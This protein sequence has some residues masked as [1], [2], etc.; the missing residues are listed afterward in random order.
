M[1]KNLIIFGILFIIVT[2]SVFGIFYAIKKSKNNNTIDKTIDIN[3]DIIDTTTDI[4]DSVGQEILPTGDFVVTD[5]IGLVI[6]SIN[7]RKLTWS[8]S[9][10]GYI[11]PKFAYDIYTK[12]MQVTIDDMKMDK[13]FQG[14]NNKG[15]TILNL[16]GDKDYTFMF[17][18]SLKIIG[19][20]N[21]LDV[22]YL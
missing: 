21:V 10:F 18:G 8:G 1:K 12:K 13:N 2:L 7:G 6:G 9:P 16:D 14:Y 5:E 19:N 11:K 4:V 22:Q 15:V 20:G 3:D 17:D